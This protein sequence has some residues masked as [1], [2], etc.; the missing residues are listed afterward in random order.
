MQDNTYRSTGTFSPAGVG[1]GLLLALVAM[2]PIAFV[3]SYA[4]RYIPF[5]YI[6]FLISFGAVFAVAYV[7]TFGESLGRNRS[8]AASLLAMLLAGLLTL[9]VFWATFLYVLSNRNLE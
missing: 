7:Y 9:F 6:N 1:L 2:F 3:Y 4:V 5:I 8:R